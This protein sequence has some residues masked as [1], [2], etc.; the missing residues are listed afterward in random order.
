[1]LD[2]M[3][4]PL[5]ES[6]ISRFVKILDRFVGQS[7]FVVITHN[8]RTISRADMLYGVTM[9]EH[10]VSKLVSVKFSGKADA[11]HPERSVADSFGKSRRL[12][13]EENVS[14]KP[15][16]VE[17]DDFLEEAASTDEPTAAEELSSPEELISTDELASMDELAAPD[18]LASMDELAAPEG[19]ASTE[20]PAEED[21]PS[22][23]PA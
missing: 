21:E 8:K 20:Q 18:E 7:Q 10:G 12:A 17:L 1:V 22:G 9:E 19:L 4:A 3:D 15:Q 23:N 13:S 5:D 6:N 11:E 16:E 14:E 2:E